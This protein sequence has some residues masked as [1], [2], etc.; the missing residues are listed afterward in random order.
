MLARLVSRLVLAVTLF[1]FASAAVAHAAPKKKPPPPPADPAPAPDPVVAAPDDAEQKPEPPPLT[2]DPTKLPPAP[3][4][5][6]VEQPVTKRPKTADKGETHNGQFGIYTQFGFGYRAI[7]RYNK[8]D[9]CGKAG[10]SVCP[11]SEPAW[12][13]IGVDYGV[14]PSIEVIMDIR[15]GLG[16][17]FKPDTS[18]QKAPKQIM[19]NPG[20]KL[21]LDEA[22]T[23]KL[24]TT[25]QLNID[26]TDYSASG[27]ATPTDFGFRNVTGFQVDLHR[28]F[29]IY[30][31]I[32]E[33][34]SLVRWASI[35]LDGGLGMQVRFP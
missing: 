9:F 33:T 3:A 18:S 22:G 17:D 15:L 10:E 14:T 13:E 6:P 31:H 16:D 30:V 34:L 20:V 28:T 1:L 25:F 4:S 7:F 32:G 2:G 12:V 21:Y 29:G 35:S 24:F 8:N 19:F 26:R 11:G 27:V 5:Q 23:T